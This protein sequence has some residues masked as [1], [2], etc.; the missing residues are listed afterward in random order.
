[1]SESLVVGGRDWMLF[2]PCSHRF[3][4]N[5]KEQSRGDSGRFLAHDR[6]VGTRES[7]PTQTI[8]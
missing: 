4:L 1:M 5:L 8:L 6:G 2:L 3:G 7:L